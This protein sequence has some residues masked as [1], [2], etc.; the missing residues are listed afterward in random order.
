M[1]EGGVY[2]ILQ[3]P[4]VTQ[5]LQHLPAEWRGLQ[6]RHLGSHIPASADREIQRH[7]HHLY[8]VEEFNHDKFIM[9]KLYTSIFK[10]HVQT[11]AS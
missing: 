9:H 4:P 2:H 11:S 8:S 10:L 1:G 3:L 5:Q 7:P 6:Q